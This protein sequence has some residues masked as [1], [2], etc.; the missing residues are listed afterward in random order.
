MAYLLRPGP[1]FGD[2][3]D[4]TEANPAYG[5]GGASRPGLSQSAQR[6]F[7]HGPCFRVDGVLTIT[8]V[9]IFTANTSRLL[10]KGQ[11]LL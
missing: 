6:P 10:T 4:S 5:S 7:S 9:V 11:T 3:C 8:R 2:S 1:L